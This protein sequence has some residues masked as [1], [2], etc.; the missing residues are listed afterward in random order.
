MRLDGWFF[1]IIGTYTGKG[2]KTDGRSGY[3][4]YGPYQP[5]KS[6]EYILQLTGKINSLGGKAYVDVVWH[7]AKKVYARFDGIGGQEKLADY[8]LLNK[9]VTLDEDVDALEVRVWVDKDTDLFIDGY[10]LRPIRQENKVE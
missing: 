6:G 5:M 8:I 10:S 4:I 3:L 2:M 7:K 1:S 9:K